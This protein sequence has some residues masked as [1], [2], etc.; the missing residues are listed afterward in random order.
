MC[1]V[2][3][4]TMLNMLYYFRNVIIGKSDKI[5]EIETKRQRKRGK[6]RIDDMCRTLVTL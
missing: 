1:E 6:K 3:I 5:K 2:S 4:V